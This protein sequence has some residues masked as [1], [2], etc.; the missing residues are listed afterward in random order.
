MQ[1]VN[2]KRRIAELESINDQLET[3]LLYV[4][5]LMRQLGF[6]HGLATVKAT[7]SEIINQ[8]DPTQ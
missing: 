4:D 7:A 2:L 6:S 8:N 1:Q 5:E 3:E